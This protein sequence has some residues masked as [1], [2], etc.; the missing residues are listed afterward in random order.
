[1]KKILFFYQDTCPYCL[2]A[3][4]ELKAL[5]DENP[6]YAALD[7]ELVEERREPERADKY[8]YWYVPTLYVDG[9][10]LHEGALSREKLEV[11]LRSA[12]D[13]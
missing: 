3:L 1:M 6:D 8:D 5:R 2:S 13:R 4:R 12:V 10:K 7:I 11:V 9:E